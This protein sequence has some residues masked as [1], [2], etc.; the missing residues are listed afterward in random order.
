MTGVVTQRHS[1]RRLPGRPSAHEWV[2]RHYG[3]HSE[4]QS[5]R[6]KKPCWATRAINDHKLVKEIPKE[7]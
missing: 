7:L 6:V 2:L 5:S 4:Q 3:N 1:A